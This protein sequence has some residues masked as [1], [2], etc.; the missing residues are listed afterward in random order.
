[1]PS[2]YKKDI[3]SAGH[4][5]HQGPS[6]DST[7]SSEDEFK[8]L[9]LSVIFSPLYVDFL[10]FLVPSHQPNLLYRCS[11]RLCNMAVW[12]E[13][14]EHLCQ[15]VVGQ[16]EHPWSAASPTGTD[17]P[18]ANRLVCQIWTPL[19]AWV[20]LW[21]VLLRTLSPPKSRPSCFIIKNLYI[22]LTQQ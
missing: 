9:E 6:V 18:R 20:E 13:S 11:F 12:T 5:G 21:S 19:V 10:F 3:G 17:H 8:S 14:D 15:F 1:M 22:H 16:Q 4:R 2:F 7:P